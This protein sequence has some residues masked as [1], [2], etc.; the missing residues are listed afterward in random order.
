MKA[1]EVMKEYLKRA[2]EEGQDLS[3]MYADHGELK[4]FKGE[5][6]KGRKEIQNFYTSPMPKGFKLTI[7]NIEG[8]D[9]K[10]SAIVSTTWDGLPNPVIL[11]E[12]LILENEK[13]KSFTMI[14]K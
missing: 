2:Q 3:D 13:I 10:C 14:P 1:V 11:E 5:V 6:F 8:D 4:N 12:R 7:Q 9:I